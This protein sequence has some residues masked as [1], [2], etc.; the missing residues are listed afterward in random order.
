MVE[1]RYKLFPGMYLAGRVE[2]LS[3]SSITGSTT[4][5]TW[6]AP[7][8]RVEA[9]GGY[10]VTRNLLGKVTY[11]HNSRDSRFTPRQQLVAAQVVL[12]F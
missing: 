2:R 10:S 7:V 9:G 5:A 6:D 1:G 8:T 12:W 4:T 11:Q 3:F